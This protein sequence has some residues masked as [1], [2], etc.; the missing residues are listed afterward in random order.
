MLERPVSLAQIE[1]VRQRDGIALDIRPPAVHF[2]QT[3]RVRKWE[4]TD[5]HRV[6]KAE[7]RDV[8]ANRQRCDEDTRCRKGKVRAERTKG[9]PQ[10]VADH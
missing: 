9:V 10:F 4:R 7:H 8:G 1:V 6:D 5:Q 2:H 3:G